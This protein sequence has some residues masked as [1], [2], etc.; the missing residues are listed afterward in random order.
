MGHAVADVLDERGQ[1]G[2][3]DRRITEPRTV[4]VAVG[5]QAPAA[6]LHDGTG[7][8][9]F[10]QGVLTELPGHRGGMVERGI[11]GIGDH[12]QA[13]VR[14]AAIGRAQRVELPYGPVRLDNDERAGQQ[15]EPFCRARPTEYQLDH[16]DEQADVRFPLG[17]GV[18]A[19]ED[20]DQPVRVSRARWRAIPVGVRQ[21][22]V[23]RRRTELQQSLIGSLRIVA[24]IDGAQDA[25]V[26]LAEFGGAEPEQAVGDIG[27]AVAAAGITTMACGSCLVAIQADPDADA[28]VLEHFEHGAI[29]EGAIGLNGNGHRDTDT[30]A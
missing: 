28:E 27:E 4:P 17:C 13:G 18:P 26:N 6:D 3:V 14:G 5:V 30:L 11:E 2:A 10:G 7:P 22:E 23:N 1:V 20:R 8:A 16:V 25:A 29:E 21:Q 9:R 15:P 12:V 19:F 24:H